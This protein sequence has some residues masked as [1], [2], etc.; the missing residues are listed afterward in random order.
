VEQCVE[1]GAFQRLTMERALEE[2]AR[3]G[4]RYVE[5]NP[6]LFK[7]HEASEKEVAGLRRLLEERRL[8]PAAVLLLYPLAS[9]DERLRAQAVEN[10]RRGIHLSRLL[11]ARSLTAEMTGDPRRP[12]DCCQAFLRSIE[13]LLPLLEEADLRVAFEPHPGDFI[14][15]SDQAVDLIREIRSPHLGYLYCMAHTFWLGD[16]PAQMI[17]YAGETLGH[18]H[19]ADTH[20]PE[21]IIQAG[22][23]ARPHNHFI[24]G[25]GEVDFERTFRALLDIGYRGYLSAAL[26]SHL[27]DPGNAA[28]QTREQVS[29]LLAQLSEEREGR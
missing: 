22:E 8:E 27:D 6:D 16:D 13:V 23:N 3:A 5:L 9:P 12:E 11:G 14:E 1:T 17:R 18:V 7:P 24:P 10:W 19:V 20:R 25:W 29:A 26:F 15:R 4:Y 2:I 21:R 28:R